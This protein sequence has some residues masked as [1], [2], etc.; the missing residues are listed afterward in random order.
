MFIRLLL[1]KKLSLVF[2]LHNLF[3]VKQTGVKKSIKI[4]LKEKMCKL[5]TMIW[6]TEIDLYFHNQKLGVEI[7]NLGLNGGN[8]DHEIERQKSI[9]KKN[10]VT[11]LLESILIDKKLI[12]L[13]LCTKYMLTLKLIL[14]KS[15]INKI[16]KRLLE[17]KFN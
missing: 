17:L 16:L 8:I 9:E 7:D 12:F 2:K 10:L 3:N 13:I 15:L 14:K 11:L 1:H 4:Y 5:N 6:A